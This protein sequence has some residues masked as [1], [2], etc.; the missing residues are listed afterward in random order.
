MKADP[1]TLPCSKHS[2][3][4]LS[5]TT[6]ARKGTPETPPQPLPTSATKQ[7]TLSTVLTTDPLTPNQDGKNS[8]SK[9]SLASG[10]H[11]GRRPTPRPHSRTNTTHHHHFNDSPERNNNQLT[12]TVTA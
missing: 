8:P 4:I 1:Q 9:S 7:T 12:S 11:Q 5:C 2:G 3:R 6:T 10:M